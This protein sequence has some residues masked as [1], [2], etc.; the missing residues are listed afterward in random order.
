M[1]LLFGYQQ[2]ERWMRWPKGRIVLTSRSSVRHPATPA[3]NWQLCFSK[4]RRVKG[5]AKGSSPTAVRGHVR[6]LEHNDGKEHDDRLVGV[7]GDLDLYKEWGDGAG[8]YRVIVAPE[9]GDVLDMEAFA[10]DVCED[11]QRRFGKF[12]YAGVIH[13]KRQSNG[14]LNKH[15]HFLFKD[16]LGKGAAALKGEFYTAGS[17]NATLQFERTGIRYQRDPLCLL[18]ARDREVLD[19]ELWMGDNG[20]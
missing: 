12:V 8:H 4:A 20:P 11:V 3:E 2:I 19:K 10:H 6:Y 17:R 7:F 5:G 16:T 14:R 18:M 13:E 1:T 9:R 15:A